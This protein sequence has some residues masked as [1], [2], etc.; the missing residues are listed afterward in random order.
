VTSK[1]EKISIL[2]L[3]AR[4]Y[5]ADFLKKI[6]FKFGSDLFASAKKYSG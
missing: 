3:V 6:G 4:S 5:T 1:E 2:S